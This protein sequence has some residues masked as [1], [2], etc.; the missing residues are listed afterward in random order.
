MVIMM[1]GA[2]TA[3]TTATVTANSTN[4]TTFIYTYDDVG[5]RDDD[6]DVNCYPP[7]PQGVPQSSESVGCKRRYRRYHGEYP[8]LVSTVASK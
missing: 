3:T 8:N 5:D 6:D 4:S 1:S 7:S 2:I